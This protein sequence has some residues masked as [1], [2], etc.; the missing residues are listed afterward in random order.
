[1]P[2]GDK[3]VFSQALQSLLRQ[4]NQFNFPNLDLVIVPK[5]S[6]LQNGLSNTAS[7]DPGYNG[8]LHHSF[9]GKRTIYLDKDKILH[10][11]CASYPRGSYSSSKGSQR[12]AGN[13]RAGFLS[14]LEILL[15]L[16]KHFTIFLTVATLSLT[17]VQITQLFCATL[18]KQEVKTLQKENRENIKK[19]KST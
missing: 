15:R 9:L 10:T 1:L 11:L 6:L 18:Q 14:K 12:I 13:S 3:Y 17:A 7:I 16:I 19:N 4:S 5:V 2:D 8:H